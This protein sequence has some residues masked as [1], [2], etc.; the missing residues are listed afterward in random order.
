MFYVYLHTFSNGKCY[1]GITNNLNKRWNEHKREA[2]LNNPSKHYNAWRKY[3]E[4]VHTILHICETR[5]QAC[6]L[7]IIEI[8]RRGHYNTGLG[9]ESGPGLSGSNHGRS[10]GLVKVNGKP[11]E[12]FNH[13]HKSIGGNGHA[14]HLRSRLFKQGTAILYIG[15]EKYLFEVIDEN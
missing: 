14:K 3:G 5:E 12:C 8:A 15:A 13:A 4:P 11:Y 6:E 9:G 7:E 1:V 2:G 10:R